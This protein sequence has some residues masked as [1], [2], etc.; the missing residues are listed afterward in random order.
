MKKIS[1]FTESQLMEWQEEIE[2]LHLSLLE[3][4]VPLTK[5]NLL[6]ESEVCALFHVTSRTLR[7]YRKKGL[8]GYIK[9]NGVILYLKHFL[10]KDLLVLYFRSLHTLILY[11]GLGLGDFGAF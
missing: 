7:T 11:V 1:L 10:Y 5:E 2:R 8:I 6:T 3:A 4:V 9:L